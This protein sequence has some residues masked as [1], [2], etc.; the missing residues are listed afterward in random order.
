MFGVC[1]A[2]HLVEITSRCDLQAPIGSTKMYLDRPALR[3]LL[4]VIDVGGEGGGGGGAVH[5]QNCEEKQNNISGPCMLLRTFFY[6]HWVCRP[7]AS[8]QVPQPHQFAS[9]NG[10]KNWR[11]KKKH[12]LSYSTTIASAHHAALSYRS[13]SKW[14]VS[15][16]TFHILST[17]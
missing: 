11:E 12:D 5:S 4:F 10:L 3:A 2:N 8:T 6:T 16:R 17:A 13:T 1:R 7:Y 9:L 15:Y 14:R